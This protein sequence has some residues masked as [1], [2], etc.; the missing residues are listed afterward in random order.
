M[1]PFAK[2]AFDEFPAE[3]YLGLRP[4]FAAIGGFALL[5]VQGKAL[6][7]SRASLPRFLL[8]GAVGFALTQATYVLSLDMTS[9]SHH[10]VLISTTPLLAAIVMPLVN[11]RRPHGLV[12]LGSLVGFV[13]VVLLVGGAGSDGSSLR[14]DLIALA[15][16]VIWIGVVVWPLPLMARYG[17]EKTNAWLFAMSLI[18][19]LPMTSPTIV[20][21]ARNPP[22]WIAWAAVIYGGLIGILLGNILWFRAIEK[23]GVESVLVYQYLP[24]VLT[25]L[26]A[27]IFLGEHV[28][29]GQAIGSVLVL[30]G[31]VVVQRATQRRPAVPSELA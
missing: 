30:A 29:W 4:T 24:P 28:T 2:I 15:S 26:I 6:G 14:G 16:A 21:V 13:G 9:V 19:I 7:F 17:V 10:A 31:V 5:I 3:A 11:R 22:G 8:C 1:G 23:S 25:L 27:V 12:L 18:T 20:D